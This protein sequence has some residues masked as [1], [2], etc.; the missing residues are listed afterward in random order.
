METF[1]ALL[2]ICAGNSPVTGEFTAQRPVTR[3]FEFFICAWTNDWVNNR[4]AGDLRR[5]CAHYDVTV[6]FSCEQKSFSCL[7]RH[8]SPVHCSCLSKL[9]YIFLNIH[10]NVIQYL[11]SEVKILGIE[12]RSD[13]LVKYFLRYNLIYVLRKE[14]TEKGSEHTRPISSLSLA[15]L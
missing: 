13:R 6:M 2:A 15:L 9:I 7:F 14:L 1:S 4:E 8:Q 3:N 12:I 5:H 10:S 11:N